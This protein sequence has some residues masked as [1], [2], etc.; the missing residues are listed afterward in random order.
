MPLLGVI[1]AE[2]IGTFIITAAFLEMQGNPLFFGFAIAGTV[3]IVGGVSGAHINPAMTI[4]AWVTRRISSMYAFFYIVAQVLG[5]IVAWLTLNAFLQNSSTTSAKVTGSIFHAATVTS[6]KE[7]YIFFAELLGVAIIAL[8]VAAAV[9][10]KRNKVV[11]AFATGFAVLTALYIAM[12]ITT[13]LLSESSTSLTFLNP[14]I[15]I[16]ANGLSWNIWPIAI[17]IL[18]PVLGGVVGFVLQDYLHSQSDSCDC[19]DCK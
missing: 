18:A 5:A 1:V 12:S 7:W 6:G 19:E 4:G 10:L 11:A 17:Y 3:L 2:F 16:A 14:A 13:V 8:G 9:R 15:A